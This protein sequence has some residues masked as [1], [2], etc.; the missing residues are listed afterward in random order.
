M[1]H[2]YILGIP[3]T[4]PRLLFDC[5]PPILL[6][7]CS[8]RFVTL[9]LLQHYDYLIIVV[10]VLL[11]ITYIRFTFHLFILY[12]SLGVVNLHCGAVVTLLPLLH[13]L[14][15][16]VF[17]YPVVRTCIRCV[18]LPVVIPAPFIYARCLL[19]LLPVPVVGLYRYICMR[20]FT[21]LLTLRYAITPRS[22]VICCCSVLVRSCRTPIPAVPYALRIRFVNCLRLI[23]FFVLA[24][25]LPVSRFYYRFPDY[26]T[27]FVPVI[28]VVTRCLF[29][30][31][32]RTTLL[33][34]FVF[35]T[36]IFLL[37][38]D[39]IICT[40]RV[41]LFKRGW[42]FV[43]P[44]YYRCVVTAYT[45]FVPFVPFNATLPLLHAVV[46]LLRCLPLL[47]LAFFGTLVVRLPVVTY[48]CCVYTF[49]F[50]TLLLFWCRYARPFV[51]DWRSRWICCCPVAVVRCYRLRLC[52]TFYY[53][54]L[55][56]YPGTFTFAYSAL[57]VT[58]RV[59]ALCMFTRRLARP[60]RV[61]LLVVVIDCHRYRCMLRLRWVPFVTHY[62]AAFVV[63]PLLRYV[64]WIWILI[65][66][67][68]YAYPR[69]LRCCL[70]GSHVAFTLQ[71]LPSITPAGL[72]RFR[73]SFALPFTRCS[74]VV[75]YL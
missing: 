4:L 36:V 8:L 7:R 3:R 58:I 38:G 43:G 21:A 55:T 65:V 11:F 72:F 59:I 67:I 44:C 62:R 42:F 20:T 69:S 47:F 41:T 29:I 22:Y 17:V 39:W 16:V 64:P 66:T 57:P 54:C 13:W 49:T 6:P 31:A 9:L 34:L 1:F 75:R 56:L 14:R 68:C 19:R 61:P 45:D 30:H 26:V 28:T 12:D 33:P 37:M 23:R 60:I 35:V 18:L 63:F 70:H 73:P 24:F 27:D 25:T 40:T 2:C 15:F 48:G 50:V 46:P 71:H 51:A 53:V 10:L 32:L 5:S 52:H 74:T